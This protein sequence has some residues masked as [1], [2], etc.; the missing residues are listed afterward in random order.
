MAPR[1]RPC[2]A[3]LK[4]KHLVA[5]VASFR[6]NLM[7]NLEELDGENKGRVGEEW[8]RGYLVEFVQQ[9]FFKSSSVSLLG[10]HVDFVLLPALFAHEDKSVYSGGIAKSSVLAFNHSNFLD[11]GVEK[12][13]AFYPFGGSVSMCPGRNL[14]RRELIAFLKECLSQCEMKLVGV[15]IHK[16]AFSYYATRFGFGALESDGPIPFEY[17]FEVLIIFSTLLPISTAELGLLIRNC[18]S[19]YNKFPV[20]LGAYINSQP[21]SSSKTVTRK[22]EFAVLPSNINRAI[23]S[24][25]PPSRW[26]ENM[27]PSNLA[28]LKS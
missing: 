28:K 3:K 2:F 22:N 7:H 4:P 27:N 5:I 21:P 12:P 23:V 24:T 25:M 8:I 19:P 20:F 16:N 17:R 9:V 18:V 6:E 10:N 14:A 11:Q 15:S 1:I 26:R 13:P